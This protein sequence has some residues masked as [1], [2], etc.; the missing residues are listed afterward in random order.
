MIVVMD[1]EAEKTSKGTTKNALSNL[2]RAP[3]NSRSNITT[4]IL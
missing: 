1:T 4:T 3:S 2:V